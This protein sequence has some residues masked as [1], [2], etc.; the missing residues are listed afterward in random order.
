MK[1]LTRE[2]AALWRMRNRG[3]TLAEIATALGVSVRTLNRIGR[4]EPVRLETARKLAK[5]G[6]AG[7][8]A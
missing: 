5:A 2:Q 6:R 1:K 7:R 4:G 8:H 3:K